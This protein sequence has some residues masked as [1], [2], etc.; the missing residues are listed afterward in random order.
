M[1][2]FSRSLFEYITEEGGLPGNRLSTFAK[3]LRDK[4]GKFAEALLEAK[5]GT[6]LAPSN[7]AFEKVDQGRLDFILGQDYLRAEMLGLHFVRERITSVDRKIQ[8]NG[9]LVS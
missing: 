4:G 9:D 7:E 1:T 3:L 8:L 5:E 2:L 6:I